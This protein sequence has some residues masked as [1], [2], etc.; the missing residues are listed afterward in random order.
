MSSCRIAGV[1]DAVR[2]L[3]GHVRIGHINLE[4][5]REL[6]VRDKIWKLSAF[7]WYLKM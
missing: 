2:H 4:I 1:E 6:K 7:R 5:K 3:R